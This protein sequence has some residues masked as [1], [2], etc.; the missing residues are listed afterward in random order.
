MRPTRT[1]ILLPHQPVARIKGICFLHW[2]GC[3]PAYNKKEWAAGEGSWAGGGSPARRPTAHGWDVF[4]GVSFRQQRPATSGVPTQDCP[5][6]HP[7]RPLLP[8]FCH[9]GF[10]MFSSCFCHSSVPVNSSAVG[11]CPEPVEG[12][13]KKL[14]HHRCAQPRPARA[15]EEHKQVAP[16]YR[17]S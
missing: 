5:T 6:F 10:V 8:L 17:Y 9:Y 3:T 1:A 13:N 16:Q 4:Y 14:G 7:N 12:R 2:W 15:H 11:V